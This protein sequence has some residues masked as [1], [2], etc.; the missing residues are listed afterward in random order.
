M[1]FLAYYFVW[2]VLLPARSFRMFSPYSLYDPR[3]RRRLPQ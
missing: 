1:F 3:S 2:F